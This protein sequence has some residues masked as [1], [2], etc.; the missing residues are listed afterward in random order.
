MDVDDYVPGSCA[1]ST[2]TYI[3]TANKALDDNGVPGFTPDPYPTVQLADALPAGQGV[4]V[5]MQLSLP[6]TATNASQ[7]DSISWDTTIDLVQNI[8]P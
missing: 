6:S 5:I 3:T 4:C 2:Y 7:G 1:A 8:T